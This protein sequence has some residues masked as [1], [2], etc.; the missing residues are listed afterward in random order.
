MRRATFV[1]TTKVDLWPAVISA[2]ATRMKLIE[3][4]DAGEIVAMK[5]PE[6]SRLSVPTV[7]WEKAATTRDSA[8]GGSASLANTQAAESAPQSAASEHQGLIVL[9]E[10]TA[11][12]LHLSATGQ[13]LPDR[14]KLFGTVDGQ[15]EV[16]AGS[17]EARAT[18]EIGG[19]SYQSPLQLRRRERAGTQ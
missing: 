16:K 13:P 14:R 15:R 2:V 12:G 4:V 11:E 9:I 5:P 1:Q 17:R 3:P 10:T 8:P 7:G 6:G 18:D 19:I